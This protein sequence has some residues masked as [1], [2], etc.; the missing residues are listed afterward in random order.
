MILVS[1]DSKGPGGGRYS[2]L[3][4]QAL[5]CDQS[6]R[7]DIPFVS[8]AQ[9][10]VE[11]LYLFCTWTAA[12]ERFSRIWRFGFTK[13]LKNMDLWADRLPAPPPLPLYEECFRCASIVHGSVRL[14][15]GRRA[16]PHVRGSTGLKVSC[17]EHGGIILGDCGL[18]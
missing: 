15:A 9:F 7:R 17:V 11:S 14:S 16:G 1:D 12:F 3:W 8:R 5:S 18:R 10:D 4:E 13:V 6:P 2:P